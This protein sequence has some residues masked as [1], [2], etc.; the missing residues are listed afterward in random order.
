MGSQG[1]ENNISLKIGEFQE[2]IM[3]EKYDAKKVLIL[4]AGRVCRPAVELLASIGNIS[5]RQWL[6]SS[7]TADFDEQNCVQVIVGS[8]YLKDAEEVCL[9]INFHVTSLITLI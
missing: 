4:G 1:K 8:L 2:T 9:H 3:D 5:S 7:I 6:K